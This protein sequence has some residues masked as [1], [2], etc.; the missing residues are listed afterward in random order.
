[1]KRTVVFPILLLLQ[2]AAAGQLP[3][4]SQSDF[5]AAAGDAFRQARDLYFRCK[6]SDAAKLFDRAFQITLQAGKPDAGCLNYQGLCFQYLGNYEQAEILFRKALDLSEKGGNVRKD[7]LNNLGWLA[8]LG[9][10]LRKSR[11]Y[12]FQAE[13]E[14]RYPIDSR[15]ILPCQILC[16]LG[17]VLEAGA[18]YSN[19][20]GHF[21]RALGM[22]DVNKSKMGN[23]GSVSMAETR[24]FQ[25]L[26]NLE[27]IWGDKT[28]ALRHYE[29]ALAAA[30]IASTQ[31]YNR[32]YYV[33]TLIDFAGVFAEFGNHQR[34]REIL[35][36]ALAESR[37][38][39]IPRLTSR[40][41]VATG[42]L[43]RR[44]KNPALALNYHKQALVEI[45]PLS[46]KVAQQA[47]LA[48]I[49]LD[50]LESGNFQLAKETFQ[51]ALNL[52]SDMS[53]KE[54]EIRFYDG[55]SGS[56][57]ALGNL[58]EALRYSRIA[59]KTI[60]NVDVR[61]IPDINK[62]SY[63]SEKH[64][65]YEQTVDLM[66]KLGDVSGAFE[67]AERSR[68]KALKDVM[69]ESSLP[70]QAS[71]RNPNRE[72]IAR[73]SSLQ[74]RLLA[75]EDSN[76]ERELHAAIIRER[77]RLDRSET[78]K[79]L[80]RSVPEQWQLVPVTLSRFQRQLTAPG[81]IFVEFMLSEP[82]SHV[83]IVSR[84]SAD[85]LSLPGRSVIE[86]EV[87]KLWKLISER[88]IGRNA[89][90]AW[91]FQGLKLFQM[92]FGA[93]SPIVANAVRLKIAPDG[94]LH[95]VPFEVLLLSQP[96][97]AADTFHCALAS[98]EI[99]YV[100]SA[101]LWGAAELNGAHNQAREF[102][103]LG[104]AG[105]TATSDNE[106]RKML[107]RKF[108][109]LPNAEEEARA[110]GASLGASK[111]KILVGNEAKES[112]LTS[113]DLSRYGIIHFAGH[114]YTQDDDPR[115]SGLL[116]SEGNGEDG[117]LCLDEISRLHLNADLVTLSGCQTGWGEI[118][119]GEGLLNLARAFMIAGTRNVIM[120]LWKTDDE[121][122]MQ[123][124]KV[125][126]RELR[127][128]AF[129]AKALRETRKAF[130]DSQIPAY[131]HPYFW[132]PFV[133]D[134]RSAATNDKLRD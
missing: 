55:L 112:F 125:F 56:F 17:I 129:P 105:E 99:S 46:L 49:G 50:Y 14:I 1:M 123:F 73:I 45:L 94:M 78:E 25:H 69:L 2:I 18:E 92:L 122:S 62:V 52:G 84:S 24:L 115:S 89:T 119:S 23:T 51:R 116:L 13:R 74:S 20:L 77:E 67:M 106:F 68:S 35:Q 75:A 5:P 104:L 44:L 63:W 66:V 7:S 86:A 10:D 85:H 95:Y 28:L 29:R 98:K 126:Y 121:A 61:M 34:A 27:R 38:L 42:D 65:A 96:A 4:P 113:T 39:G 58:A 87:Q 40:T 133:V 80:S 131:R 21:Y 57:R 132:A 53:S 33:D 59:V 128:S 22:L 90:A 31:P 36:Q 102:L 48:E 64:W 8:Y 30:N 26:G 114:A 11:E 37:K 124:M 118:K 100:P 101:S 12:L 109:I 79:K 91:Q 76:Q 88:P 72:M 3:W 81:E 60:E 108:P 97:N 6:Y 120:S 32:A 70:A 130:F 16:N 107:R 41:L 103:A 83:W 71:D 43:L 127:E 93:K 111:G 15:D 134:Q 117:Y 82:E 54:L 47:I 110:V 19:A 9:G